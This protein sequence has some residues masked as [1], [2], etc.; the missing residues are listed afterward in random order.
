MFLTPKAR[1]IF[2]IFATAKWRVYIFFKV[3]FAVIHMGRAI[4]LPEESDKPIS[5]KD[6]K[7]QTPGEF[8][9]CLGYSLELSFTEFC[10]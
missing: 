5:V 6:F 3:K 8:T 1:S 10:S 4:Y 9:L 7:P 2:K